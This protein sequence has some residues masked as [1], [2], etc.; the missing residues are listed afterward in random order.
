MIPGAYLDFLRRTMEKFVPFT[1]EEWALFTPYLF[2]RELDKKDAF[3]VDG[4]VCDQ[5]GFIVSG[6][7]RL[8][9]IKD[10][11]EISNYFSFAGDL[12]SSFKSYLTQTPSLFTIDAMEPAII[13]C[14]THKSMQEMLQHPV[15]GIK[16][17]RYGRL[18]S[19]YLNCCYE[20]RLIS[21]VTQTPE[22]RYCQLLQ[23]GYDIMQ[24]IPQHYIAN[25]LGITP[26]S[27]SRIR[28][29]L[30]VR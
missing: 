10:G 21:F 16:M 2:V 12:T 22:E 18:V 13:L 17:E 20:D 24:R 30:L 6:S 9:Y 25:Y 1:E 28:K 5:I 14:Y 29:R 4:K 3:V 8:Y 26:V 15:L 7:V 11:M 23:S 19:E 27:L